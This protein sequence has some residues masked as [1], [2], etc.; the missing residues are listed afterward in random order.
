MLVDSPRAARPLLRR[1]AE[2]GGVRTLVLTHR[3]DVAD[4][5]IFREV[6]GCDR[7]M[8]EED[9]DP[10]A[11]TALVEVR[12]SGREAFSLAPDLVAIPLPGHTRGSIALLWREQALFSGDHLF[13]ADLGHLHASRDV[14][15]YS[16]EEQIRSMERLLHFRFTWVL[17]GHGRR[18]HAPTHEAMRAELAALIERMKLT[19]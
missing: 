14:C 19:R 3:D 9:I 8:H 17:P 18:Y 7:V 12:L 4:H 13:S 6:F 2:L 5:R 10:G 15:W 1:I 11:D 16:W